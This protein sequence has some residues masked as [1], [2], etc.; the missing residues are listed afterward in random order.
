MVMISFAKKGASFPN[1]SREMRFEWTQPS[2]DSKIYSIAGGE[3]KWGQGRENGSG[4]FF[5]TRSAARGAAT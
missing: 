2:T 1:F 3:R 5:M 4:V